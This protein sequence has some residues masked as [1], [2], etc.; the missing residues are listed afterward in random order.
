MNKSLILSLLI[1]GLP[2]TLASA[3]QDVQ[4]PDPR[5]TNPLGTSERADE[6]LNVW[7]AKP[8]GPGHKVG[9]E[10]DMTKPT[11]KLIAGERIIKLGNVSTPQLHVFHPPEGKRNGSA[12]VIC[13]GG[14]F[15]ILAWDLEGTEVAKWLNSLGFTAVVLKYR[16]PSPKQ[17]PR[18]LPPVQDAQRA[19]SIVREKSE[20]WKINPEQVGIL[21][22]S[23]GGVTAAISSYG[24][25]RYYEPIDN[26][27]K[28]SWRPDFS[29][30]IYAAG[31]ADPSGTKL[32]QFFDINVDSPPTFMAHAFDDF[33]PLENCL[34][35]MGAL[36][37]AK[38]PSELHIYDRGG[39]GY[40]LRHE[41]GKPVTSWT[42][43]CAE[44]LRVRGLAK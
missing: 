4:N 21:G 30:L 10:Q 36:K 9:P 38:V 13:P 16:V 29:V 43:R 32:S 41:D 15:Y 5:I 26:T 14:G 27:D 20:Q 25:K 35:L 6:V 1:L 28:Q 8:P 7:P 24:T 37:K 11:D 23:A 40:G 42:T 3:Q 2:A 31:M 18:W 17:E 44:W 33:V 19:I 34:V 22:F 12:V 39:H